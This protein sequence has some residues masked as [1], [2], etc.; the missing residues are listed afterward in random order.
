MKFSQT[1]RKSVNLDQQQLVK[2]EL[3]AS[4]QQFPL[5]IKPALNGIDL[6]SWSK[7]NLSW[8]ESQLL[9]Y[10]GILFRG[11]QLKS[12]LEFQKFVQSVSGELLEYSYASTPRT[13]VQG[14]IYTS[15]EYPAE[16]FIPLHNE[17]AYSLN[18]PMKIYFFCVKAAEKGGETPLADSRKI[19]QKIDPT[20][21]Q[22]FIDKKILYVRNYGN[23]LDLQWEKVF[24]TTNKSEVEI[25]CRKANIDFEWLGENSLRTRQVCQ[26]FATHPKT[27][28]L[29]WFNQAHLFHISNS[30]PEVRE[31]LLSLVKEENLPRNAFF[32]DGSPIEESVITE[33][34][35]IYNQENVMFPWQEGDLLM[36]DNMLVAHGRNPFIGDR[37]VLVGMAESFL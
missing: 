29:V 31:S 17:M 24:Q 11:F 23:G 5:V 19:F 7:N 28:D 20:I 30:P 15:T 9:N 2:E 36:L 8:L 4:N 32:G 1:K 33:I 12:D 26:A 21:R 25:Y 37:K 13:K 22:K 6:I 3:I 16:Q 34:K 10:G 14:K 18:W 27:G 35:E